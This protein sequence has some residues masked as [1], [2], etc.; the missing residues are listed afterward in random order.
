MYFSNNALEE[1]LVEQT[2]NL[3]RPATIAFRLDQKEAGSDPIKI[4]SSVLNRG[5]ESGPPETVGASGTDKASSAIGAGSP[6][7]LAS[8]GPRLTKSSAC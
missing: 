8:D 6:D 3:A 4:V 7:L 1:V 5:T 2:T